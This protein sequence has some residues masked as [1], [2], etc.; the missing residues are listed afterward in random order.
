VGLLG[1]MRVELHRLNEEKMKVKSGFISVT[2]IKTLVLGIAAFLFLG[3][4]LKPAAKDIVLP[5]S[6]NRQASPQNTNPI[7]VPG[8]DSDLHFIQPTDFFYMDEPFGNT[9]WESVYLGKMTT[10]PSLDTGNQAQFLCVSSGISEW[11]NWWAGTSIAKHSDLIIG[12]EIIFFDADEDSDV[13]RAP[14]SNREARSGDWI[15]SRITDT[16]ELLHGFVMVGG[17]Y[18]VRDKNIRIIIK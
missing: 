9:E 7:S 13:Y 18:V 14:V 4:A 8:E 16:S 15:I 6:E 2:A 17:G 12:T 5:V 11:A 1:N 3:C 10:P